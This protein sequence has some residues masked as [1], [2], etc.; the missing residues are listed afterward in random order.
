[1]QE[2][3]RICKEIELQTYI[4]RLADANHNQSLAGLNWRL[5][6]SRL[7]N[8]DMKNRIDKLKLDESLNE[9]TTTEQTSSIVQEC[10]SNFELL[11]LQFHMMVFDRI[12]ERVYENQNL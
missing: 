3:K 4:N 5:K 9:E 8:E 1:M 6:F 12:M 2:E 11:L 7:I 10:V